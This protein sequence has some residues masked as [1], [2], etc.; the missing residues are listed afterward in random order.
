M[1]DQPENVVLACLCRID[2][3]VDRLAVGVR[4]VRDR[5]SSVEQA[6]IT[7]HRGWLA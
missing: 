5:L 3:K 2:A 4:E 7:L 6:V 1:T